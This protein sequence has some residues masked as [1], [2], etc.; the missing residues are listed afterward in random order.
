MPG[1]IVPLE[2][3]S[4]G[5]P[6]AVPT[7]PGTQPVS[8]RGGHGSL[9]ERLA[10]VETRLDYAQNYT[11][12]PLVLTDVTV[13][14][15][16]PVEVGGISIPWGTLRPL[17]QMPD[18][19]WDAWMAGWLSSADVTLNVGLYYQDDAGTMH[20]ISGTSVAPQ[21][22][23][24][25]VESAPQQLRGPIAAAAGIPQN[26]RIMTFGLAADLGA[27]GAGKT[28]IFSRWTLWMRQSPR[29]S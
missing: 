21:A 8:T 17:L 10:R 27:T 9:E 16:V 28:A 19:R 7:P 13:T 6:A 20:V 2:T 22:G 18:A 29:R 11:A 23:W 1:P 14:G 24:R 25:K 3:P 26:E 4:P 12:F 5:V 15:T